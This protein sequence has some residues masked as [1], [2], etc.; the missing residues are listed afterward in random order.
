MIVDWASTNDDEREIC[1]RHINGIFEA[2]S[3]YC[4]A[5]PAYKEGQKAAR[6]YCVIATSKELQ[7]VLNKLELLKSI[8]E[9]TTRFADGQKDDM[10]F[11]ATCV[12]S[13]PGS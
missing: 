13:T 9:S 1:L 12:K 6:G 10:P 5:Y 3:I 4:P 8:E 2:Q 7:K 11:S